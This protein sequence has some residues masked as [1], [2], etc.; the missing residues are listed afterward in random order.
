MGGLN[1]LFSQ[2]LFSKKLQEP[3]TIC[4]CV[5]VCLVGNGSFEALKVFIARDAE[6]SKSAIHSS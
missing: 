4:V 3:R 5:G 1:E 6:S 2:I